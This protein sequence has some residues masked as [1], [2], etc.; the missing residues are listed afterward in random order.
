MNYYCNTI[1]ENVSCQK[2]KI[3]SGNDANNQLKTRHDFRGYDVITSLVTTAALNHFS[4]SIISFMN[5]KEV[6]D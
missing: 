4:L 2:Y 5:S 3:H 1:V 6:P